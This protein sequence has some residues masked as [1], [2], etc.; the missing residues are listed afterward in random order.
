M[1]NADADDDDDSA[2]DDE[3]EYGVLEEEE[4]LVRSGKGKQGASV[5][6]SNRKSGGTASGTRR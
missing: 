1:I 4:D 5:A 2:L 3:I 6:P